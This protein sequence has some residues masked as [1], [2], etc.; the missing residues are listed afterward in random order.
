[1]VKFLGFTVLFIINGL[2][3]WAQQTT[4]SGVVKNADGELLP[5]ANILVLPDS[6]IASADN[7]GR[8]TIR[9]QTG[10]KQIVITYTGFEQS[11]SRIFLRSD[12]LLTFVMV[13]K[14][15]ELQEVTVNVNR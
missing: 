5:L 15:A 10:T 6:V 2:A 3:V 1:M 12:T 4:L 13:A 9:A 11:R 8:F 14:V 7:E